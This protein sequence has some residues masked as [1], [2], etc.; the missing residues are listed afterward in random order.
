MASQKLNS[1]IEKLNK[2]GKMLFFD[3]ATE[4]QIMAFEKDHDV[5][6][7]SQYKDWLTLS[8]GGDFFLPAGAQFYGV[9]RKPVIDVNDND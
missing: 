9:A 8:D 3:G 5:A 2:Q 4:E 7:P 1:I 6:L